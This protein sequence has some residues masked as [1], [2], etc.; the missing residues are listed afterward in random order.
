[1]NDEVVM[2]ILNCVADLKKDPESLLDSET[3]LV[4]ICGYGLALDALHNEEG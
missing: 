3:L 1:M 4:A 2:C